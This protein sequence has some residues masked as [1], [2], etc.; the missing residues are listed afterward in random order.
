LGTLK[1]TVQFNYIE[2]KGKVFPVLNELSTMPCKHIREWRYTSTI[3]DL[4]T[5]AL[6]GGEWSASCPSHFTLEKQSLV[7]R[8]K[9]GNCIEDTC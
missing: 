1:A 8:G 7:S 4:G 2:D 3:L 5:M 6:D 9:E